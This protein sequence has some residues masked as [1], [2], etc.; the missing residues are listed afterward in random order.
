MV[1]SIL[2][3]CILVVFFKYGFFIERF[4][5]INSLVLI[6]VMLIFWFI[7]KVYVVFLVKV[8]DKVCYN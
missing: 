6:V 2:F 5:L 8:F 1:M 3:L 7:V 4:G